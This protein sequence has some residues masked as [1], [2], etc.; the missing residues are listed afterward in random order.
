M[1]V[2]GRME[3]KGTDARADRDRHTWVV[4]PDAHPALTLRFT[5]VY[6]KHSGKWLLAAL[7]NAVPLPAATNK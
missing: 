5:R 1:V 3:L 2:T 7:H 6:V 4:D